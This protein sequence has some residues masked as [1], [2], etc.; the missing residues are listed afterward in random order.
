LNL[1]KLF[2]RRPVM[3]VAL[4]VSVILFGLFAYF[5]LPVSDQEKKSKTSWGAQTVDYEK[6]AT[7]AVQAMKAADVNRF[8]V[9]CARVSDLYCPGYNPRQSLEKNSNLARTSARYKVDSAKIATGVRAELSK[10]KVNGDGRPAQKRTRL[11]SSHR[12]QS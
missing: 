8:L 12:K 9:V 5:R 10:A 2:I 11:K 6:I 7:A 3:T 1:S 4:T